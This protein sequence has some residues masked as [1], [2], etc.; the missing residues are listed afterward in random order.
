VSFSVAKDGAEICSF[1][2]SDYGAK[3]AKAAHARIS[4]RESLTAMV[5]W[6]KLLAQRGEQLLVIRI[7]VYR[8]MTSVSVISM[9]SLPPSRSL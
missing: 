2:V 3:D 7:P 1:D 6:I 5:A 4:L 8:M 9:G